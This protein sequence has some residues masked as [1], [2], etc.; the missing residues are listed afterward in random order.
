LNKLGQRLGSGSAI[1]NNLNPKDRDIAMVFQN[2]AF[3][4]H[5]TIWQRQRRGTSR[6]RP[7]RTFVTANPE[8]SK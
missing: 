1:V 2:Y 8:R 5:M 7:L 3:Y 4:P 6:A